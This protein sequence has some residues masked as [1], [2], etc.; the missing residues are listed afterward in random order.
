[1]GKMKTETFPAGTLLIKEGEEV[2]YAYVITE[3]LVEVNKKLKT[4]DVVTIATLGPGQIFGE[5]SLFGNKKS[6]AS[7]R[8][9]TEIKVQLI[10][11]KILESY[12]NKTPPLI[13]MLLEIFAYRLNKT[14]QKCLLTT[15][16]ESKGKMFMRAP[17]ITQI[18]FDAGKA[19][20]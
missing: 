4:K 5:M 8:A 12:L 10:D 14:S 9:L 17:D 13:K 2:E 18:D 6:T 7:V 11:K 1:M 3:G 19:R 16:L 20:Q 15:N